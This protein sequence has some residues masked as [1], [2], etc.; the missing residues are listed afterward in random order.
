MV[1]SFQDYSRQCFLSPRVPLVPLFQPEVSQHNLLAL[2]LHQK[3]LSSNQPGREGGLLST[4]LSDPC[5]LE[6]P[7]PGARFIYR[8]LTSA[9]WFSDRL[10]YPV[11][12]T[13]GEVGLGLICN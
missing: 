3:I 10:A 1:H 5:T 6:T 8:L 13:E 11:Y 9:R 7:G 2:W 4:S 12:P